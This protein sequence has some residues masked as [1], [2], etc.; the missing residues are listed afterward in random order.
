LFKSIGDIIR[1]HRPRP[2]RA[3][4]QPKGKCERGFWTRITRAEIERIK[5]AARRFELASRRKGQR[6]GTLGPIALEI[7]DLLGNLVDYRS[8]RLDPAI[9][10]LMKKL[11]RSRDAVVRALTALRDAGFL[12]WIRRT[13][14]TGEAGKRPQV[15]QASN[16]YRLSL[17]ARLA[18][19]AGSYFT[20]APPPERPNP[21]PAT[22][23]A[24]EHDGM[25][26][27]F[28]R[29]RRTINASP[30][31]GQEPDLVKS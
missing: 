7:L 15:K 2:V 1:Q 28:E 18:H 17:P 16:A 11:K 31:G 13:E 20:K 23:E 30:P 14:P 25:R 3:G 29:L 24:I 4:S 26:A 8:G 22:A 21:P 10:Y 27:A 19:L 9:T 12:D 5:L 6:S